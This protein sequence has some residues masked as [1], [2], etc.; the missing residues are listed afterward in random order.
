VLVFLEQQVLKFA[1]RVLM[2][3]EEMIVVNAT[4]QMLALL[5]IAHIAILILILIIFQEDNKDN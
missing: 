5:Q 4:K 3:M 2:D 1:I